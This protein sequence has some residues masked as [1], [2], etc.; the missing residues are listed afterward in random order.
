MHP[1]SFTLH[2]FAF[3][4]NAC[5]GK[6]LP[7][8]KIYEHGSP[9]AS[10]KESFVKDIEKIIW[11]YKLSPETINVPANGFVQEIQI[12]KVI[13]KKESI[14]DE[15]LAVIDKSI[16]SPILYEI[17]FNNKFRYAAAYKRQSE[18]DKTKWVV[19]SY[20]Y[21]SWFSE[22]TQRSPIPIALDLQTLYET[23]IANI[24]PIRSRQNENIIELVARAE[25]IEMKNREAAQLEISMNREKQFNRK[26][27][28][29]S[30]LRK[31]KQEIKELSL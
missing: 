21:T 31:L 2:P 11:A 12:F 15:T 20:F 7:K 19:S 1:S 4:C 30:E 14:K 17:I 13:L 27:E 5:V 23:L 26:V 8:N 3:P 16:P 9:S 10:I 29:N 25:R 24:L 6:I 22:D 28:L 18:S